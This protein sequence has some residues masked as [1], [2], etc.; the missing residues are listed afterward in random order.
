M[1]LMKWPVASV[2]LVLGR[3][4][5]L[6]RDIL[7]ATCILTQSTRVYPQS[8]PLRGLCHEVIIE[9]AL[10]LGKPASDNMLILFGHLLLNIHLYSAKQKRSQNLKANKQGANRRV[11]TKLPI[12]HLDQMRFGPTIG[13]VQV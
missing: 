8:S 6:I 10:A 12:V 13:R 7:P 3:E 11:G 9:T 4:E 1:T 2:S 5:K